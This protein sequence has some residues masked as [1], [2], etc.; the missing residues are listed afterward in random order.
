MIVVLCTNTTR[1][2]RTMARG[3]SSTVLTLQTQ[4]RA[5]RLPEPPLSSFWS[6]LIVF[7]FTCTD[8]AGMY[9][10]KNNDKTRYFFNSLLLAGDLITATHSHQIALI[11]LLNEQASL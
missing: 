3:R 8:A 4:V 5:K 11:A 9:F 7:C 1:S 6:N 10:V 2:S